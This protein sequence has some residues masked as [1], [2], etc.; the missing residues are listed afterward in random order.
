MAHVEWEIKGRQFVNCNCNYGCPCQFDV[1][2]THGHCRGVGAVQIDQGAYGTVK[3]DG[4]RTALFC[5][6]PGPVHE[7]HGKMQLIVDERARP[8]QREALLKIMT[9]QDTAEE[10][11]MWWFYALC[12]PPSSNPSLRQSSSKSMWTPGGPVLWWRASWSRLASPSAIPSPGL[13]IASASIFRTASSIVSPRWAAA[14][15]KR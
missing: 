6:W 4:L 14:A 11:T 9:G 8:E 7:G 15:R 1:S 3:L 13:N 2:P 10:A 5:A 12:V